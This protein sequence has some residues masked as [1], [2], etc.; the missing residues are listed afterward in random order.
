MICAKV[1]KVAKPTCRWAF[2]AV[3]SPRPAR[4][5]AAA[6]IVDRPA[7]VDLQFLPVLVF[8]ALGSAQR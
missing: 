4:S 8:I 1:S 7:D 6:H 2:A 5:K 3:S